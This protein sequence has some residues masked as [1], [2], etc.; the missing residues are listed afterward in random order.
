MTKRRSS[1]EGAV[2]LRKD[3]RYMGRVYLGEEATGATKTVETPDGK[4]LVV[5]VTRTKRK[6]VYGIT[7]KEV[8]DKLREQTDRKLKGLQPTR[9]RFTVAQLLTA[10]HPAS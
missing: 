6:T 1:G 5:P 7:K 4:T 10:R 2:T 8:L 9:E 3:G